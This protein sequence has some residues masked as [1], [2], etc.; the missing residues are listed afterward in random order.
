MLAGNSLKMCVGV[1]FEI[2]STLITWPSSEELASVAS[3]RSNSI[4]VS[5]N[6]FLDSGTRSNELL[7]TL[8]KILVAGC[9]SDL[10]TIVNNK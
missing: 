8:A 9:F 7:K 4:P 6:G 3:I 2:S 5:S 10:V 1:G